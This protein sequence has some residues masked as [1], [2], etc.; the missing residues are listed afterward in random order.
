MPGLNCAILGCNSS[1]RTKGIFRAPTGND[2][3]INDWRKNMINAITWDH[4][5]DKI[6]REGIDK[7]K[8]CV[9]IKTLSRETAFKM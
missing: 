1:G 2:E 4:V 6:L 3:P 7:K 5:V 8:I 9:W